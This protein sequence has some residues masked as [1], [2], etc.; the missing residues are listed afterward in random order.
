MNYRKRPRRLLPLLMGISLLLCLAGTGTYAFLTDTQSLPNIFTV[1]KV[2][3][4][5]A[6]TTGDT[7]P[8]V[9]G[10]DIVKDPAV[11]VKAGSEAC[12][13]FVRLQEENHLSTYARYRTAPGWEKLEENVYYR[14]VDR[15]DTDQHFQ[16]LE[17][18]KLT[19]PDTVT[20]AMLDKLQ[21]ASFPRLTVHASACQ[22][23]ASDGIP[24]TP[25]QA[26]QT[27]QEG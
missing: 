19:V 23:Y 8:L 1:G 9:P 2:G 20:Q 5:L 10:L 7:Y 12:W 21:E 15:Q 6:E 13:L 25:H 24:F 3:I 16:V 11:T 4:R 14:R 18:N 22:Y 27:L 26:W 17:D